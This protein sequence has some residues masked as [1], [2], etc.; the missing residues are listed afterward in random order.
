MGAKGDPLFQL[1]QIGRVEFVVQFGLAHQQNLQQLLVGRLQIGQKPDFFQNL[2]RKVV[3]LVDHQN[4]RQFFLAARD[5]IA[6]NLQQQ[7]ALVLADRR[8]AQITRNVLQEFDGR[9]QSVEYI[10]IGNIAALLERLQQAAQ[11]Q[12]LARSHLAGKDDEAFVPPDA[13]VKRGQRFVMPPGGKQKRRIRSDFEGVALQAVK[14][15]VHG[16]I[17]LSAQETVGRTQQDRNRY[18]N[19]CR[20]TE[21]Q[22]ARLFAFFCRHC[23]RRNFRDDGDRQQLLQFLLVVNPVVHHFEGACYHSSQR[24]SDA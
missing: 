20:P 19:R 21:P 10:G 2:R 8:D 4:R 22:P 5:H 9:K 14:G 3:S 11:Q 23:D 18:E 24:Q 7:F 17:S 16:E 12:G 1:P 15:L 13:V 6:R